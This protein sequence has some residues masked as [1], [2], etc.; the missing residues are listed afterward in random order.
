MF[1]VRRSLW[2]RTVG[3]S[4]CERCLFN[5]S[6][7]ADKVSKLGTSRRAAGLLEGKTTEI[8]LYIYIYN[9]E[10]KIFHS[11]ILRKVPWKRGRS[12]WFIAVQGNWANWQ[13][14]LNSWELLMMVSKTT[15][16]A[17]VWLRWRLSFS[18]TFVFIIHRVCNSD[19]KDR[20]QK[21]SLIKRQ[22]MFFDIW[23][24][25]LLTH[26]S[27]CAAVFYS[28]MYLSKWQSNWK[29]QHSREKHFG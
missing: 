20:C 12:L 26:T 1:F 22:F 7:S 10:G 3:E 18:K 27:N 5:D 19:L 24:K 6:I 11:N 29:C 17:H 8:T 15:S 14:K 21:S 28:K 16:W 2:Q 4:I 25:P 23:M 13:P 9:G